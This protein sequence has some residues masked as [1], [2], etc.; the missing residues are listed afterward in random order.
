MQGPVALYRMRADSAVTD[1]AQ[2]IRDGLRVLA[3]GYGDD[4]RVQR[5]HPDHAGGLPR[6]ELPGRK[7]LFA[8]WSGGLLIGRGESAVGLMPF[9]EDAR[10]PGLSPDEVA[11]R[12]FDSTPIPSCA[13]P[14][15]WPELLARVSPRMDEFLEALEAQSGA[16]S[17]AL[18]ARRALER[19]IA[20]RVVGEDPVTVGSIRVVG[21]DVAGPILDVDVPEGVDR[22]HVAVAVEGDRLAAIELPACGKTVPGAVVADAIAAELAWPILGRFFER[23][24][25]ADLRELFGERS[26]RL[27]ALGLAG[28]SP[29]DPDFDSTLHTRAGWAIFLQ[30]LWGRPVWPVD[31]FYDPG[32]YEAPPE[33]RVRAAHGVVAVEVS[34]EI[35]EVDVDGEELHIVASVGGTPIGAVSIPARGGLVSA[36]AVRVAITADTGL[37]LARAAVREGVFGRPF[38]RDRALRHSLRVTART[39]GMWADALSPGLILGRRRV[40]VFGTSASRRS[41]LPPAV[42]DVLEEAAVLAGESVQPGEG[43][44]GAVL[45]VPELV[46]LSRARV[47]AARRGASGSLPRVDRASQAN[48]EHFETLFATSSDPWRYSSRYEQTKYEQT[49]QLIPERAGRA[50]ELACAEG[51]FTLML[52]PRVNNLVATDLSRIALDRAIDRCAGL[53]NVSFQRLDLFNDPVPGKFDLIVCSEVLYFARD[54]QQLR[55][56]AHKLAGALEPGGCLVTAHA[57]LVVDDPDA[58]GYDW[59][60]PFGGRTIGET[61]SAAGLSLVKELRMPLYRIQLFAAA[62]FG[63]RDGRADMEI[64]ELPQPTDP[65]P[66]VAET[67]RWSGGMPAQTAAA[68]TVSTSSL[69]VLMYHRVSPA[70]PSMTARYRVT[71]EA[72]EEQLRYLRDA[73]YQGASLEEW[74][75]AA[76]RQEALPGRAILITFDGGYR[77]FD[78]FAWPLLRRYGFAAVVLVVPGAVGGS[79]TWDRASGEAVPLLGWEEIRRLRDDG[80]VFGAHSMSHA[81]LTALSPEEVVREAACSRSTLTRELTVAPDVFAYPYG[82]TDAAVQKLVG[83]CGYT[84]GVTTRHGRARF[85]DNL[86]AMPRIEVSGFDSFA[87]FVAKLAAS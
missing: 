18:R 47:E 72:F 30:E 37:E 63:G 69:P 56:L 45:G 42:A 10:D 34:D 65:P 60:L 68:T 51:H 23:S 32:W 83:A 80:V 46:D 82:D 54:R 48:R 24:V 3:Q 41:A 81:P 77:D 66:R 52:A 75:Q 67:V 71:P 27:E 1:G 36:H 55:S 43:S 70:G 9:V 11:E 84:Y 28:L 31:S 74:R 22:L 5:P 15:A 33:N 62:P 2:V 4:P 6:E 35:P 59:S 7:L 38:E 20:E 19:R 16:P 17:L 8:A 12:L 86:L 13:V 25:Y 53:T 50:L 14:A 44:D 79:N 26:S 73:G 57:N 61:L 78:V 39:S 85:D 49:L 87:G 21:V 76:H 64:V 40:N 29:E 58:P